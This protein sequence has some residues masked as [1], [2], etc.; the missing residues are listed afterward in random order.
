MKLSRLETDVNQITTCETLK[1]NIRRAFGKVEVSEMGTSLNE[2]F[3]MV[4]QSLANIEPLG[5]FSGN[6]GELFHKH[7]VQP[8]LQSEATDFLEGV[9]I[10]Y[11]FV[12]IYPIILP[13]ISAEIDKLKKISR[14]GRKLRDLIP[15]QADDLFGIIRIIDGIERLNLRANNTNEFFEN[16]QV[17]LKALEVMESQISLTA[18]GQL[19]K[20]K[21]KSPKGNI[22]IRTYI[23]I[24][25]D[26]W[27]RV[28]GRK[29]VYDGPDGLNGLSRFT[30]FAFDSI[31]PVHPSVEHSQI[32]YAV[33]AFRQQRND[34]NALLK[35]K[36]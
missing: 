16:L 8:E 34:A 5:L 21:S 3:D 4:L 11:C 24:M 6:N 12:S 1:E 14:A 35:P 23:S 32:E 10:M 27:T 15:N 13:D 7:K 17:C 22:A 25:Y 28:L 20:V 26:L 30:D 33:R 31:L 2:G 36:T 29:F 18:F 19:T 9:A